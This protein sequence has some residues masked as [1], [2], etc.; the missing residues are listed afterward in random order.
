MIIFEEGTVKDT[1]TVKTG[2]GLNIKKVEEFLNKN[3]VVSGNS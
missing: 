3:G 1:L 2:K